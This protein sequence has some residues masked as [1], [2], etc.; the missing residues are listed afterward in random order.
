MKTSTYGWRRILALVV[1]VAMCC[2]L[3]VTAHASGTYAD[4]PT[5]AWYYEAVMKVTEAS[6]F[7]GTDE[8]HFSPEGNLTRGMFVTVMWRYEGRP[9]GCNPKFEDVAEKDYYYNAVG[10]ACTQELVSGISEKLFA[11]HQ[12]ITREQ[13]ATMMYRYAASMDVDMGEMGDLDQYADGEDVSEFA[14]DAVRWAVGNDLLMA[15]SGKI[16]PQADATRAEAAVL[17]AG[18]MEAYPNAGSATDGKDGEDG[19]SAYEL[20]VENGYEGTVQEWL[21][22]LVGAA[23]ADGA[24]AYELAVKNG[25]EGTETEWLQSLAG[26]NGASA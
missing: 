11:P 19:K 15:D 23:G 16:R 25:Y 18:F 9:C 3:G 24:S 4:V 8:T 13:M 2:S 22:S 6:L 14:V 17:W 12:N 10:W 21:A 26:A 20:A 7:V 1:A 5:D